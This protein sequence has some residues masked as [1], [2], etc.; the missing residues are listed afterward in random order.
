MSDKNANYPRR[1]MRGG[2]KVRMYQCEYCL[3]LC[4][5]GERHV[6]PRHRNK[7]DEGS[8]YNPIEHQPMRVVDLQ[9]LA[10]RKMTDDERRRHG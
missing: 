2:G 7:G 9:V 6:H 1:K 5:G 10:S 3:E 4:E 8:Y